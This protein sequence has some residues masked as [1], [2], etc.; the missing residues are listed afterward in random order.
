MPRPK[1]TVYKSDKF[2]LILHLKEVASFDLN[3][4]AF[5]RAYR[6]DRPIIVCRCN[7]RVS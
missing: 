6:I 7:R 2:V 5:S 3:A 1:P 4:D